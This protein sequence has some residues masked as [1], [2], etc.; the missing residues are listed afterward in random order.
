MK[1]ILKIES[2]YQANN[3][4]RTTN[5]SSMSG[6]TMNDTEV[7]MEAYAKDVQDA[8]QYVEECQYDLDQAKSCISHLRS[9]YVTLTHGQKQHLENEEESLPEL[10]AALYDAQEELVSAN[11]AY[12][13]KRFAK[14]KA[15]ATATTVIFTDK[16]SE[17]GMYE[18]T[19]PRRQ[20][21]YKYHETGYKKTMALKQAYD[22]QE[23]LRKMRADM[24]RE[25]LTRKKQVTRLQKDAAVDFR[26][27]ESSLQEY[28]A[29]EAA[30]YPIIH[31][32]DI[33]APLV[34][35][36]QLP[37][38][39]HL[40]LKTFDQDHEFAKV[41]QIH[42]DLRRDQ[43][44]SM[45]YW[46]QHDEEREEREEQ[47]EQ[48]EREREYEAKA[49]AAWEKWAQRR[50]EQ[51]RPYEPR[52]EEEFVSDYEY[53]EQDMV[54]LEERERQAHHS[55]MEINDDMTYQCDDYP[56]VQQLEVVTVTEPRE[57]VTVAAAGSA[58]SAKTKA[59]S[60]TKAA[61]AAKARIAKKQQNKFA[62]IQ[63]T[64]NTNRVS[65][66]DAES[67]STMLYMGKVQINL[68]K[69]N[70]QQHQQQAGNKSEA[71][72]REARKRDAAKW[73]RIN[74]EQ[75]QSNAR[76]TRIANIPQPRAWYNLHDSDIE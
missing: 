39:K 5:K 20:A 60:K 16:R 31:P 13:Y 2:S 69:R 7:S 55:E 47:E 51:E 3:E 43:E 32:I 48:E 70:Q 24:K 28:Y 23:F 63:V 74:T 17:F 76:G 66:E 58:I 52:G 42:E 46:R 34:S 12:S 36:V 54:V 53:D 30:D 62:P 59:K 37:H 61:A 14:A 67:S 45:K 15:M 8:Q 50:Y 25:Y 49:D 75:K 27:A 56:D 73:K 71:A 22:K 38:G 41:R 29:T 10:E 11:I 44:E 57:R 26:N 68:L 19:D 35:Q 1:V 64:I 33:N 6:T 72:A 18:F 65:V 9:Q 40:D 4:Q 21:T